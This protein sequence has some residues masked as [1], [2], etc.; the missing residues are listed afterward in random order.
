MLGGLYMQCTVT[1]VLM[2][3][4]RKQKPSIPPVKTQQVT[5]VTTPIGYNLY[6]SNLSIALSKTDIRGSNRSINI[7]NSSK[8]SQPSKG[9]AHTLVN[10]AQT[11]N[12]INGVVES[13]HS[14]NHLDSMK[15]IGSVKTFN[16]DK[17]GMKTN[18]TLHLQT[19]SAQT[20]NTNSICIESNGRLKAS[21]E[22]V[23]N[24]NEKRCIESNCMPPNDHLDSKQTAN[25]N[26][27]KSNSMRHNSY[28]DITQTLSAGHT[29][30]NHKQSDSEIEASVTDLQCQKC[31]VFLENTFDVRLF[32]NIYVLLF[33]LA[34]LTM[35]VCS[36]VPYNFLP[37]KC[38]ED[39]LSKSDAA[40][41]IG[42]M[43]ISDIIGRLTF[44]FIGLRINVAVL[45]MWSCGMVGLAVL[46]LSWV[47]TFSAILATAMVFAFSQGTVCFQKPSYLLHF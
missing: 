44:G 9:R 25:I 31:K 16:S 32:A 23:R 21:G 11:L 20:L 27:T 1:G 3:P 28:Q 5:H 24:L 12:G 33:F 38:I 2:R 18:S 10:S 14:I 19:N 46:I 4:P 15:S 45:Y 47:H 43:G 36:G 13:S 39:G 17:A 41:V 34:S 29:E 30:P 6:S 42:L 22:S 26:T 35:S 40:F 8:S 37:V 7:P